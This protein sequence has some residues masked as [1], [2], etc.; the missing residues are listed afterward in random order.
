VEFIESLYLI[1][2]AS[3]SELYEQLLALEFHNF[4]IEHIKD[5]QPLLKMYLT[6][7]D[8]DS[9]IVTML[10]RYG[11]EFVGSET[12]VELDWLKSWMD[13]LEEFELTTGVWVNP[14]PDTEFKKEG[15]LVLNIVPGTAFGTGMHATTQL[16]AT[17][18][19]RLP[20]ASKKVVDIGC[21]TG[22]LALLAKKRGASRVVA[23]DEDP[24]A[25]EKTQLIFKRNGE[26]E[27]EAM[28]SDLLHDWHD[29]TTF[30]LIVANIIFE[31]LD[32]LLDDPKLKRLSHRNTRLVFSGVS[33]EKLSR[34]LNSFER[35]GLEVL[36]HSK[37]EPWNGFILRFT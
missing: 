37:L 23:L 14:F 8:D 22:I 1:P 30:D 36:Q 26:S 3:E 18:L 2:E 24:L 13:T 20:V 12:L 32:A 10:K 17:L 7:K 9:K 25:I 21:G 28:T 27:V 35:H 15:A 4:Y 11:A 6:A 31:V 19:E 34:M 33:D 29:E 16:A 5:K